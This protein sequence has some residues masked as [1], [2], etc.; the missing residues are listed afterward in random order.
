MTRHIP[1]KAGWVPD[2]YDAR[3]KV[4]YYRGEPV[5]KY[6]EKVN[7]WEDHSEWLLGAHGIYNQGQSG[8]CVA[9]A[10]A[11]AVRFLA[12][13]HDLQKN[14][15]SPSRLFIY[16]NAR[17]IAIDHNE[18]KAWPDKSVPDSGC[19]NRNA[20]KSLGVFGVASNT[21]WPFKFA[22]DG[23]GDNP[24]YVA[25]LN[26]QPS[27]AAYLEAKPTPVIEYLRLDPD[28]DDKIEERYSAAEREAVGATTL[29]TMKRCLTEGYPVVFSFQVYSSHN[30]LKE[31]GGFKWV[32][33]KDNRWSKHQQTSE[34]KF[35]SLPEIPLEERHK[36][37]LD[38]GHTVLAVG[39]QEFKSVGEGEDDHNVDGRVLCQNSYGA[40]DN[41]AAHL[42]ISY[43]WIRDFGATH[44]FWMLRLP[45]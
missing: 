38:N 35:R 41:H 1:F 5:S 21:T 17:R 27:H 44:D 15:K 18:L 2:S 24:H 37:T 42:W 16:Y 39:F 26:D 40:G 31:K 45:N 14:L 22:G 30:W 19:K 13:K 3:D 20:M 25:S 7:L 32:E 4:Y 9:N 29:T 6:V 10:T 23:N 33:W 34:Q 12:F 11:A 28:N 8:S 36:R 43:D